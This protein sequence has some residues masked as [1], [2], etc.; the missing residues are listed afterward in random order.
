MNKI[1]LYIS[2]YQNLSIYRDLKE[3]NFEI[4][5]MVSSAN[6]E[7]GLMIDELSQIQNVNIVSSR[8]EFLN[9]VN[10]LTSCFNYDYIFP[11]FPEPHLM[12]MSQINDRMKLL[13]ISA[14]CAEKIK[15]KSI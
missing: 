9:T 13:G 12:V 7:Y 10:Y 1:L 14:D 5:I 6:P 15:E 2:G 8:E 4:D 11:T 3:N